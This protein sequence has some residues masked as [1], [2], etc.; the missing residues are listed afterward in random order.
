MM[1]RSGRKTAGRPLKRKVATRRPRKTV[2]VF[3]EGE[4]TEPDY[5]DALK[6]QDGSECAVLDY[7]Q[8]S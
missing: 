7:D 1:A 6:R 3:C 5:L 8:L 2:V 4:K